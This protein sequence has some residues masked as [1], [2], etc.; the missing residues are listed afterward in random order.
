MSSAAGSKGWF[1]NQRAIIRH[2]WRSVGLPGMDSVLFPSPRNSNPLPGLGQPLQ[3]CRTGVWWFYDTASANA[4]AVI[5]CIDPWDSVANPGF[6]HHNLGINFV[7]LYL[8]D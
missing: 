7:A 6:S 8:H 1:A 4:A 2:V 3:K 5:H